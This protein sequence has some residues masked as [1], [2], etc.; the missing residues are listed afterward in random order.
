MTKCLLLLKNPVWLEGLFGYF[1]FL[2]PYLILFVDK[3]FFLCWGSCLALPRLKIW[4]YFFITPKNATFCF[5]FR[6][7]WEF[8]IVVWDIC[9]VYWLAYASGAPLEVGLLIWFVSCRDS[10]AA[11]LLFCIGSFFDGVPCALCVYGSSFP[12]RGYLALRATSM[13]GFVNWCW[14]LL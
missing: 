10:L 8:F 13:A 3:R 1:C 2:F 5:C 12:G 9:E 11:V 14:S 4:F 7:C 6:F